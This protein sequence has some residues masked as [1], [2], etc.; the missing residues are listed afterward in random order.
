VGRQM[1]AALANLPQASFA[2]KLVVADGKA[3]VSR[4]VDGGTETLSLTLP[5]VGTTDQR[6]NE[7]RYGTL[8]TIVE[9]SPW[10]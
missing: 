10:P 2:S 8:N 9:A 1:L 4:E 5:A 7:P 6:L 3:T